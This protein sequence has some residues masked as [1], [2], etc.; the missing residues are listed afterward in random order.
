MIFSELSPR[1]H[2]TGLVTLISQNLNEFELH[3]RA[4]LGLPI[5]TITHTFAASRV[6]LSPENI[7]NVAYQGIGQAMSIEN[8]NILIF[9]K[10][11]A[12][13][14]RRMGV[15]LATGNNLKEARYKADTSADFVKV[16]ERKNIKS[17]Q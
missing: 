7:S 17:I 10:P 15:A 12:K 13:K 16:I 9:G 5:P 6:I 1:P 14:G 4:I 11:N 3:L 8:S 2:D